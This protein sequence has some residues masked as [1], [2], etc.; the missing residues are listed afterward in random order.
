M[1][2]N[3]RSR[4]SHDFFSTL[5]P[6]LQNQIAVQKKLTA[7]NKPPKTPDVFDRY[8]FTRWFD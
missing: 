1:T 3:E 5:P 4:R 8:R 6:Q 7:E 2:E